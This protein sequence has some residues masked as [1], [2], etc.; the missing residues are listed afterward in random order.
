[1]KII[2]NDAN[3]CLNKLACG[4]IFKE[5]GSYYIVVD[6]DDKYGHDQI[7]VVNLSTGKVYWMNGKTLVRP[8]Q[9]VTLYVE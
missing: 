8:Y 1:M 9:K 7:R 3:V 6:V 5:H 2:E 4:T